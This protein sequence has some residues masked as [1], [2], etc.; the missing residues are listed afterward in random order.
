M[1]VC[2]GDVILLDNECFVRARQDTRRAGSG[3]NIAA[4]PIDLDLSSMGQNRTNL[5]TL[6]GDMAFI[7]PSVILEY[8]THRQ[9]HQDIV[10]ALLCFMW[11]LCAPPLHINEK[12]IQEVDRYEPTRP[13]RAA[14]KSLPRTGYIPGQSTLKTLTRAYEHPFS[15]WSNSS[16]TSKIAELCIVSNTLFDHCQYQEDKA[17]FSLLES[18]MLEAGLLYG[19]KYSWT[20]K[21]PLEY[22]LKKKGDERDSAA[23]REYLTIMS[24]RSL[25]LIDLSVDILRRIS[26]E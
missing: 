14:S 17:F 20:V 16:A 9:L 25:G 22:R 19:C 21:S 5:K 7:A 23:H 4:A 6:T 3:K 2:K 24:E 12:T 18:E 26:E 11:M 1:A 10:S 15:H 8:G 13:P